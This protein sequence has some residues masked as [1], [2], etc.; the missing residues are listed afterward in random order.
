MWKVVSVAQLCTGVQIITLKLIGQPVGIKE[1][2]FPYCS[3]NFLSST[4][5]VKI[6]SVYTRDVRGIV[7]LMRLIMEV[8]RRDRELVDSMSGK[9][10]GQEG[11]G[12]VGEGRNLGP[13]IEERRVK[14]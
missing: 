14:E 1:S 5:S 2:R 12:E 13:V 10:T 4:M 6:I 8:E 7:G 11:A 9:V 3:Q